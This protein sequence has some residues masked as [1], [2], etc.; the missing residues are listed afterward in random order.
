VHD[1]VTNFAEAASDAVLQVQALVERTRGLAEYRRG[2]LSPSKQAALV[3]IH[4][5]LGHALSEIRA[6]DHSH[7]VRQELVRFEA[8]RL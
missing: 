3:E 6:V 5:G 1:A 7:A 2:K 4:A 8:G